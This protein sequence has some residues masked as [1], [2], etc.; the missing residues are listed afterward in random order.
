MLSEKPWKLDAV[1]RLFLGVITTLCLGM[2]L[3]GLV[4]HYASAWPKA[5]SDFWQI[6]LSAFF[7]EIPALGWI[8]FFLR[9]HNVSWKE[10]FGLRRTGPVKA[11]GCGLLAATLFLP[12]AWGCQTISIHLM[13]LAH[14]NPESQAAVQELQDPTLTVTEKTVLGV[15]I[16]IFAPLAEGM[17][18]RGILY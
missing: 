3:A 16:I 6:V 13:D 5:R 9:L 14:M 18:F 1:L 12:V 4:A 7:L 11:V 2:L 17:L 10:A 15:I 8:G